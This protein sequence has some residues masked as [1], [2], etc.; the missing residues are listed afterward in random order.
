MSRE[1]YRPDIDGLR[2]VAVLSVILFHAGFEGFSGGFL[3][4]DIFFVISGFLITGLIKDQVEQRGFSFKAFY[5]RRARRLL[6][7]LLFTTAAT[8]AISCV[9]LSPL[10]LEALAAS[11]MASNLSVSNIHF[12]RQSGYFDTSAIFKPLLHTWSLSVEEQF[13]LAWP[14]VMLVCMTRVSARLMPWLVLAAGSVSWLL[15]ERYRVNTSAI[16]FLAPFRVF[17]F[18]IGALVVWLL[19][20]QPRRPMLSELM[21]LLGLALIAAALLRVDAGRS[22]SEVNT[23]LPCL[24]TALV[25]HSGRA[26]YAGLLLRNRVAVGIGLVSYSLYLVHW[27]LIVFLKYNHFEPFSAAERWSVLLYALA[28]AGLMYHLVEKPLRRRGRTAVAASDRR[29]VIAS[30][31]GLAAVST[32]ALGVWLDGGLLHRYPES[33]RTQIR[34]ERIEAHKLYTWARFREHARPFDAGSRRKVLIVGDS[35]AADFMNVL[36]ENDLL[37]RDDVR[38]VQL[39]RHCQS[40]ITRSAEQFEALGEHDQATC[41]DYF[42]A[43]IQLEDLSRADVVVLAFNWYGRGIPFIGP[44][45]AALRARGVREVVVVGRKSQGYSGPD[46]VLRYGIDRGAEAFSAAHRNSEAWAANAGIEALPRD[47]AWIDLMPRVCPAPDA[48]KVFDDQGNILFFDG[49]HLTPAGARYLGAA[50]LRSGALGFLRH[51]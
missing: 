37:R 3:G 42:E 32:L 26:R 47:F 40:L 13:Y 8:L 19:R 38:T 27:P 6:P 20:W 15:A 41:K 48:C 50:L 4:V 31:A 2:A 46:I 49:S 23:V 43:W 29:F 44:A 24:G 35:Q 12:Y 16:F 51:P 33:I 25:L 5:L 7:A 18:A 11:V 30:V 9:L 34:S 36:G 22:F 21:V 1:N 17:E 14:A 10:Y 28:G 45:V 39:D